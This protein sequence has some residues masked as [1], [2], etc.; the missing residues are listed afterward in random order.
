MYRIDPSPVLFPA[1]LL[2]AASAPAAFAIDEGM[3]NMP[4]IAP[5]RVYTVPTREAGEELLES[6]GFGDRE[7]SV[8]M[9]NLM[10][11]EG[12]GYE[13]MEMGGHSHAGSGPAPDDGKKAPAAP[14]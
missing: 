5:K 2:F 3:P 8:R 10:M 1:L 4:R 9:M 12:S 11:V 14:K 7:P 6:R 13:G